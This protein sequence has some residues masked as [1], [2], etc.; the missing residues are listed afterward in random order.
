[1]DRTT[2][3]AT[4]LAKELGVLRT[5]CSD[6]RAGLFGPDSVAWRLDREVALFLGA[7]RIV[8]LQLAHPW[9]A[10]AISKHST[11]T[12]DPG[13][14]I[15]RTL[16]SNFSMIFGSLDQAFAAARALHRLH[17]SVRGRLDE[18]GGGFAAQ[19]DYVAN[20]VA[21]LRWVWATL[22]ETAPIVYEL[23]VSPLSRAD[24]AQYYEESLR[25]AALFGLPRAALPPDWAAFTAYT[26]AMLAPSGGLAVTAAGRSV[27]AAMLSGSG[28]GRSRTPAWF[29]AVTARFLPEH[30]REGFGLIFDQ[31]ERARAERA[32][33]RL[34]RVYP[35][36]PR[37]LRHIGPYQEAEARIR[38]VPPGLP[39]RLWNR[40]LIGRPLLETPL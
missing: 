3:K 20:D 27:A 32:I 10:D 16:D 40:L 17:G 19:A 11:A 21:A 13:R 34:R 26:R 5:T 36:L 9:V 1:M 22:A 6:P 8:L 4:D 14:R 12:S 31:A 29:R 38:G 2:V 24:L 28:R 15:R 35:M 33:V 18:G 25:F 39:A 23:V 37:R 30:L 7:G